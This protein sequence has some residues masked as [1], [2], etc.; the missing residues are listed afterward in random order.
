MTC[1]SMTVRFLILLAVL[2]WLTTAASAETARI[3]YVGVEED[4]YY[5]PRPVYTGL[6]LEDRKRPLDGAR[7]AFRGT[8]VLERALDVRFEFEERMLGDAS[9]APEAVGAAREAGALAVLLDLPEESMRAVL[10]AEGG[11]GLLFNIR[12]AGDR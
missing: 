2:A 1:S 3:V 4:P 5:E 6:S 8:R 10:A 9:G 12:H 11:K 7:L